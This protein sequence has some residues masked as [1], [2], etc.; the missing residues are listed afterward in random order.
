MTSMTFVRQIIL[1]SLWNTA[2]IGVVLGAKWLLRYRLSARTQYRSWYFLAVSLL[3]PFF[4]LG[5]L[6]GFFPAGVGLRQAFTISAPSNST[7]HTPTSGTAWLLDTTVLRQHPEADQIVL[8]LLLVWAVGTLLMATLYCLGN[9]RL[10]RTAKSAFSVPAQI[11][12][13]F[14]KTRSELNVNFNITLCQSHFLSSPIS[15]WWGRFFVILPTDRLKELSDTD[16]ENILRHELTHIRHGDPWTAYLFCGIQAI[17]WYHPLVWIAFRQMRREREAYCDW[18]VLNTLADEEERIRYGQTILNFA[19]AANMRFCTADGL[20]K[21]KK[22]LR[23]RLEYIVNFREDTA[24][25]RF[26]GKCCAV[27]MT[28]FVLGQIPFLSV[29]ADAGETY[30]APPSELV[31]EDADWSNFFSGKDGCAV[32]YDQRTDRYTVYNR[33]EVFHRVPPCSTYKPYS[34]LNALELQLITP[35]ENELSWD[36]TDN[37]IQS[38]NRDHTLR[39]AMQESVNWYFQTLDRRAGAAQLELFFRRIGYGNCQL[40]SNL[41]NL[42]YGSGVKI[43]AME[44]VYLLKE[45]CSNGFGADPKNIATVKEAISLN[46]T[47]FYG[48]TG[49]GR[50]EDANIAGW[51]I[52]FV[53]SS[54]NTRF[55]AVYLTSPEGADGATAYEIACRILEKTE[56]VVG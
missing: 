25:K 6:R 30:Y 36:R 1:G 49:T 9:C 34:A 56:V 18:A 55:I 48:K 54:E 28:V 21:G 47:G 51:F 7:N 26:L 38:W 14:A 15:F 32:L 35:E 17:F 50:L 5:I 4:P 3:L 27:L 13:E 11:Q 42:W 41:E 16:L 37:S 40:G 12:K 24:R 8:V 43:S 45:L 39:S 46:E 33:E 53:E 19:V 31:V 23:Y 10:Y 20:C 44:Q 29:C 22:Q 2:L 52:G